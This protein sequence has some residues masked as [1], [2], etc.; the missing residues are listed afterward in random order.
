[1]VP[2]LC[3]LAPDGFPG[4]IEAVEGG[5]C[6]AEAFGEIV[7]ADK[8]IAEVGG[9]D[10]GFAVA[11]ECVSLNVRALTSASLQGVYGNASIAR[12]SGY[13][14]YQ[15]DEDDKYSVIARDCWRE[16]NTNAKYPRISSKANSNN[17]APSDFWTFKRNVFYLDKIQVTYELPSHLFAG[18]F[19]K[20]VSVFASGANLLTIS[21]EREWQEL[22]IGLILKH[23]FAIISRKLFREMSQK[24]LLNSGQ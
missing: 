12:F 21:K 7:P 6:Q 16:D 22:S 20:G 9:K 24:V 4:F 13:Q 11:E 19:I 10:D 1:M 17:Y 18:T 8:R 15:M 23:G 2:Y 14:Y 5:A 3:F